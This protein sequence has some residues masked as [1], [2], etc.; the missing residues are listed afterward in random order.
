[1]PQLPENHPSYGQVLRL[2]RYGGHSARPSDPSSRGPTTPAHS[3]ATA[4]RCS[5]ENCRMGSDAPGSDY[6][7]CRRELARRAA[8]G[9]GAVR[10]REREWERS[11]AHSSTY[12]RA[13]RNALTADRRSD[14]YAG[15]H[16]NR[17]AGSHTLANG[18]VRTADHRAYGD[19]NAVA[20]AGL[21]R[22]R[23]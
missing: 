1:M 23:R 11:A 8:A 21:A 16:A 6:R 2:L 18:H 22:L 9:F 14:S 15:S 17:H 4:G 19:A 20:A 12:S 7:L 10:W 13:D 3:S 5:G